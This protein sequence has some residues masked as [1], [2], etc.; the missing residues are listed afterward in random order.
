MAVGAVG[1][2]AYHLVQV[3]CILD[4]LAAIWGESSNTEPLRPC[5]AAAAQSSANA[6]AANTRD[7]KL[8]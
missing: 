4:L 3:F 6:Q 7:L 8:T 2:V 1:A 5:R